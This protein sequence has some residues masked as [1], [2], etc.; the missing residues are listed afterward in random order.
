MCHAVVGGH[1]K[2]WRA[3]F[4]PRASSLTHV[5]KMFKGWRKVPAEKNFLLQLQQ[6]VALQSIDATLSEFI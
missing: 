5:L 6:K 2:S 4:R 3:A 1:T